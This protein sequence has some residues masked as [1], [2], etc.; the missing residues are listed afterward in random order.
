MPPAETIIDGGHA[1]VVV[2]AHGLVGITVSVV[3]RSSGIERGT[4][5]LPYPSAG[6][7]GHQ[8]VVSPSGRYLAMFLYSGQA[9]VGYELF[10]LIPELVHTASLPYVFGEGDAPVFS[11]DER[12]LV[13]VWESYFAWWS[14]DT[15]AERGLAR[16]VEYGVCAVQELPDGPIVRIPVR[17]RV[18]AG[19]RPEQSSWTA[20]T[21][22][23]FVA[24]DRLSLRTPWGSTPQIPFP[25]RQHPIVI[26]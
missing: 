14:E 5:R 11:P 12:A 2:T 23:R 20:P 16:E 18:P 15:L 24:R 7:G 6:Y 13:M 10:E 9:E 8:L 22:L 17:A 3:E 26:E 19:W 4:V 1:R 21:E 25:L